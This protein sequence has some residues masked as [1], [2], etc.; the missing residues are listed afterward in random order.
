MTGLN[1]AI[2]TEM[3]AKE[4]TGNEGRDIICLNL[5]LNLCLRFSGA[6]LPGHMHKIPKLLVNETSWNFSRG[7]PG[8]YK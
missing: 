1:R 8:T 2:L 7:H 5:V 3:I 6:V 4:E